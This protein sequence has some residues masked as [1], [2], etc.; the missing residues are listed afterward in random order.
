MPNKV[1]LLVDEI[2]SK[3]EFDLAAIKRWTFGFS[4]NKILVNFLMLG[5][6]KVQYDLIWNIGKW[7]T[8]K[9]RKLHLLLRDQ[10]A[11]F[12]TKLQNLNKTKGDVYQV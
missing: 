6:S 12:V 8:V 1:S 5:L 9:I 10:I 7:L 3:G 11:Q 4:R 2:Y